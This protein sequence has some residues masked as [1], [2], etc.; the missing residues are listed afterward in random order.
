MKNNFL[1]GTWVRRFLI[2]YIV[3]ERNLSINTQ[4][5][6]RDTLLVLL[7]FAAG[8]LGISVD[9]LSIE[10][11]SADCVR[12]F[13][14]DL[15]KSRGCKITTRNH[16]LAAIRSLGRFIGENSPEHIA[17][18][19][20]I[21]ALPIKKTTKRLMHYLDKEEMDALLSSP[22]CRTVQGCRDHALLLFLYNSGARAEEAACLT[23]ADLSL[24]E[25]PSV[26]LFGKGRKERRCPLW[27]ITIG[28]LTPL[29]ANREPGA[30]VFL[31]RCGQ[32]M[33]RF[34]IH[35]MV[36][37]HVSKTNALM[38]SLAT[39]K[40]SPH[41]IRHS[42]AMALLRAGVDI[43]AIRAWLGHVSIDTTNIYAEIDLE[44]KAKALAK[45]EVATENQPKQHW[46]EDQSL[47]KFLQN[48]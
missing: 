7:P 21:R 48:L 45:F 15:E 47:M 35:T 3:S 11:V 25:S 20:S 18:C 40:I 46:R 8:K 41:T 42:T 16:R 33:T 5:S 44:M 38:P 10:D 14:Q 31:N 23:I 4:H 2:E 28:A 26:K 43:N 27:A 17:W 1:I 39:K 29:V 13:L 22:D 24:F 30:R 36:E 32:P 37:R 12:H 34:G 19:G 6:Y 9:R